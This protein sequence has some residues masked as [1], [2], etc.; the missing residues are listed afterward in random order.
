MLVVDDESQVREGMKV[1]LELL[2]C[3][4]QLA[5][6]LEDAVALAGVGKPDLALVDF[7]LR[8]EESGLD[9]IDRLRELHPALPAIIVSGDTAP[10]RL[11]QARDA[12]IQ[13]LSKPVLAAPLQAA[14]AS[15]CGLREQ[16]V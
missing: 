7:R 16:E 11:Q 15:A 3:E 13:V 5:S 4:V 12:G 8:G 2:D 6:G 14:M 10:D 1:L 9:T